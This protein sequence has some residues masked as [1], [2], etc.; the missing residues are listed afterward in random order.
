MYKIPTLNYFWAAVW[1]F[2]TVAANNSSAVKM[3]L[4]FVVPRVILGLM[5]PVPLPCF[6]V[7]LNLLGKAA[8]AAFPCP[9]G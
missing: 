3:F 5:R 9:K 7:G 6:G 8:F 2:P 4:H 1:T